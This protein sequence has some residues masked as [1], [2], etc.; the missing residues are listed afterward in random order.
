MKI[1]SNCV[2]AMH[3]TLTNEQGEPLDSSVGQD[4]LEYIHGT[5]SI[6]PGLEKEL[7]GKEAG[8]KFLVVIQPEEA[9]GEVQSELMMV[10]PR[11]QFPDDQ[12]IEVGMT[13]QAQNSEGE[14]QMLSIRSVEGDEITVDGN[15][16]LA[17]EVLQFDVSVENVRAATEEEVAHGHP[18]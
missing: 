7:S 13:F 16:P 2:V 12:D 6:V 1:D 18:H 15:H 10:V 14:Q 17:G 9:Y 3:Y 5:A 4:P 11:T 8:D